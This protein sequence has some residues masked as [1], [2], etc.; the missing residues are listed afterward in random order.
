MERKKKI[1]M[2]N[3]FHRDRL[4]STDTWPGKSLEEIHELSELVVDSFH[5]KVVNLG[6]DLQWNPSTASVWEKGILIKPD[7]TQHK[8]L[9][10]KELEDILEEC[11]EEAFSIL[12]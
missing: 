4:F 6:N 1:K 3:T 5:E 2:K 9:T 8:R 10:K 7:G 11:Y 12:S